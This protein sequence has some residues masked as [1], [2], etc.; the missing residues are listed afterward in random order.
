MSKRS[1]LT[2]QKFGKLTGIKYVNSNKNG[3]AV[4]LCKC[5]CGC[6]ITALAH[7]IKSGN[8]KSCG[9]LKSEV[10]TKRNTIH[11]LSLGKNGKITKLYGVWNRMKQRCLNPNTTDSKLY[12]DRGITVCKEWFNYKIFHDWAISNGYTEGLTIERI[13]N[14]GNYCPDNCEWITNKKQARNK[15]SNH[16]IAYA[17][18]RKTLAEWSEIL[19]IDSSLLRYRLKAWTVEKAFNTP[20]RGR[21]TKNEGQTIIS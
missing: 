1:D 11:G 12:H 5:D 6:I 15:R 9:C 18:K 7:Q 13:D 20:I 10:A 17:G 2:G 4:W 14:D 21:D 8:T 19:K 3:H 16:L